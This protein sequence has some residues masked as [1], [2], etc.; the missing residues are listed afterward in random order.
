MADSPLSEAVGELFDSLADDGAGVAVTFHAKTGSVDVTAV[1][2]RSQ[3]ESTDESGV[4]HVSRS[5]DWIVRAADLVVGGAAVTPVRGNRVKRTIG[6]QVHTFELMDP[7][8][9][10]SDAE[11]T[12]LRLHTK[13]VSVG[14]A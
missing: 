2:G 1:P 8:F 5:H 11:H 6:S 13:R 14:P 9:S 7:P 3:L 4:T 12:V 10:P